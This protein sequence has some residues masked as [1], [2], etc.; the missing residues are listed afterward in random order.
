MNTSLYV[1]QLTL[2]GVIAFIVYIIFMTDMIITSNHYSIEE[3]NYRFQDDDGYN[4]KL[5]APMSIDY[6][7]IFELDLSKSDKIYFGLSS[8]DTLMPTQ[9]RKSTDSLIIKG[10]KNRLKIQFTVNNEKELT[11]ENSEFPFSNTLKV[12]ITKDRVMCYDNGSRIFEVENELTDY[13][14][15]Y[16]F[17]RTCGVTA[18]KISANEDLLVHLYKSLIHRVFPW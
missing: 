16:S 15:E 18:A 6:P 7:M 3:G 1:P 8:Q 5:P 9:Y 11:F 12:V 13:I 14:P 2:G 17:I 10:D 4:L